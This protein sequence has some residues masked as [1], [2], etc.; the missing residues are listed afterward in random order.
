MSRRA[1]KMGPSSLLGNGLPRTLGSTNA[2]RVKDANIAVVPHTHTYSQS[3]VSTL[4]VQDSLTPPVMSFRTT[5]ASTM[6]S[7]RMGGESR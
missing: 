3:V 4:N 5:M 2:R 6:I 1:K 7:R